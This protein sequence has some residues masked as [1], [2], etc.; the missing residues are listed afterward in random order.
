VHPGDEQRGRHQRHG[1]ERDGRRV[2]RRDVGAE[3]GL[4]DRR[5]RD[6]A[7]ERRQSE[8]EAGR[9]VAGRAPPHVP[10]HADEYVREGPA[11]AGSST[12]TRD[13][14]ELAALAETPLNR[15]EGGG[16]AQVGDADVDAV[17]WDFATRT[18]T[19]SFGNEYTAANA[20]AIRVVGRYPANY[21]FGRVFGATVSTLVDTTVAALGGVGVQDCLKPWAVSYQT[22]LQSLFPA[23]AVPDPATYNLTPDD[24]ARLTQNQ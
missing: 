22:L 9:D 17:Q 21:T 4:L 8:Q 14:P 23:G 15:I 19:A 5:R 20:N 6:G 18:V 12:W 2:V 10:P 7:L 3:L 16:A 24:I 11:Y 13:A 1:R